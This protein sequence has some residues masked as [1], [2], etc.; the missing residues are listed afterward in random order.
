[1]N[2]ILNRP[3]AIFDLE[4][5]GVNVG[6]DRIVEIAI[7]KVFPDYHEE[8]MVK[9]VNPTIPIPYQASKVH[10]IFDKDV[11]HEQTFKEL[12]VSLKEF[13]ND[14]D[15]AGYNAIKFDIPLL[16]EEFTRADVD[17]S[18]EDRKFVDV[19]N[20]FHKKE[21]RTL[22]AAYKFY[23]GKD[24]VGAHGAEADT[25]ATYEVLL[26]Q[27]ERYK[28]LGNTVESLNKYSSNSK[29][30]DFAGRM[31]YDEKGR[32]IFNF[33]K[34]KGKLVLDVITKIDPSYYSWMMQGDFPT[35]TKKKLQ[36]I[37]EKSKESGFVK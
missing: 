24:L 20:I 35:S 7:L 2:L 30:V 8:N 15:F 18:M 11:A 3:I 26:A 29:L 32:A 21:E 16:L 28:D 6:S 27:L 37:K 33:G 17:F 22:V 14:C 36:E 19:Q 9:R 4:T 5:T 13:L 25:R 12:A 34:H 31:V 23:C 10:G 1:M